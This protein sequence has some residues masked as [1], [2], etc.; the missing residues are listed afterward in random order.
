MGLEGN[1]VPVGT[2]ISELSCTAGDPGG[3]S[4]LLAPFHPKLKHEAQ[5][6]LTT[7]GISGVG[8]WARPIIARGMQ[9]EDLQRRR[10][11]FPDGVELY[12]DSWLQ[13]H[14]LTNVTVHQLEKRWH[15]S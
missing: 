7:W 15:N 5:R 2:V 10:A 6:L 9:Q 13:G 8:I 12:C 1:P 14:E 11:L 3:R 4:G